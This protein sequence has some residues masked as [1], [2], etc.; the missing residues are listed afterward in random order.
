MQDDCTTNS[1]YPQLYSSLYNVGRMQFLSLGVKGL[2]YMF[3]VITPTGAPLQSIAAQAEA[4]L[5]T[6]SATTAKTQGVVFGQ[7]RRLRSRHV[8][9]PSRLDGSGSDLST[10]HHTSHTKRTSHAVGEGKPTD[11]VVYFSPLKPTVSRRS[12]DSRPT[13]NRRSTIRRLSVDC[14]STVGFRGPKY[15]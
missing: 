14:R 10:Y 13:A 15:I 6:T 1:H 4:V 7:L 5:I 3:L 12:V 2:T 11:H 9:E 8:A